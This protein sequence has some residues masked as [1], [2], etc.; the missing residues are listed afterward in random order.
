MP[1]EQAVMNGAF[2]AALLTSEREESGGR[3][4]GRETKPE[5]RIKRKK[6]GG[7]VGKPNLLTANLGRVFLHSWKA[8][9]GG[10]S[11]GLR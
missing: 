5:T 6:W 3:G 4:W 11:L 8:Q 1:R 7:G 10:N 2:E 9:L